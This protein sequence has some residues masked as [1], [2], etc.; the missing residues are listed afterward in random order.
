[1]ST[2]KHQP[3]RRTKRERLAEMYALGDLCFAVIVE[4]LEQE[5]GL[6]WREIPNYKVADYVG[7]A[8]YTTLDNLWCHR[9]K[10]PRFE[11]LQKLA[12]AAAIPAIFQNMLHVVDRTGRRRRA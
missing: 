10:H 3:I 12:D 7:V 5:T 9:T 8:A 2:K 4:A 11:T 1:M 6:A